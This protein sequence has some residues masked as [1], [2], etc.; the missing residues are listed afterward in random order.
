MNELDLFETEN[1]KIQLN[2]IEV[3]EGYCTREA[4]YGGL[5][6]SSKYVVKTESNPTTKI[7]YVDFTSLYPDFN[8]NG[9]HPVG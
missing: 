2:Q 1:K 9:V 5:V 8:K 3:F 4:F 7:K 6:N